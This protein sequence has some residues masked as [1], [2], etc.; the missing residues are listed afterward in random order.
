MA[1][2]SAKPDNF[3]K[4]SQIF[5]LK[6]SL[7]LQGSPDIM[8]PDDNRFIWQFYGPQTDLLMLKMTG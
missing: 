5:V 3:S 6:S 2:A 1:P 7:T 4:L 8:T